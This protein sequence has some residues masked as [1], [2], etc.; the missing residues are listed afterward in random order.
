M[1]TT[2]NREPQTIFKV[3]RVGGQVD[4]EQ[5]CL[6]PSITK[7]DGLTTPEGN[8]LGTDFEREIGGLVLVGPFPLP[9]MLKLRWMNWERKCGERGRCSARLCPRR[10]VGLWGALAVV[11]R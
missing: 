10:Q 3:D 5:G 2:W 11:A 7:L 1:Q 6:V 8:S 4:M 9:S